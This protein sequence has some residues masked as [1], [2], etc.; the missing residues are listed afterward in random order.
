M[1]ITDFEKCLVPTFVSDGH[2]KFHPGVRR[3]LEIHYWPNVK[4]V[5]EDIAYEHARLAIIDA[6]EAANRIISQWNVISLT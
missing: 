3:G 1:Q 4:C 5:N 6:S 2:G